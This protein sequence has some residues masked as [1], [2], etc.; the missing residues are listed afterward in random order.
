MRAERKGPLLPPRHISHAGREPRTLTPTRG[1]TL[2][3]ATL[4]LTHPSA[5]GGWWAGRKLCP[6][7]RS[8]RHW[9]SR[10]HRSSGCNANFTNS[11]TFGMQ[12]YARTDFP[13]EWSKVH[14]SQIIY[15]YMY[16]HSQKPLRLVVDNHETEQA[17]FPSCESTHVGIWP[18]QEL[19]AFKAFR[20]TVHKLARRTGQRE[21]WRKQFA[22]ELFTNYSRRDGGAR[23]CGSAQRWVGR[24]RRHVGCEF[25]AAA[26]P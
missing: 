13:V 3:P 2:M 9:R 16:G 19:H 11:V 10:Q 22:N 6:A 21:H 15:I 20:E 26:G 14:R 4:T 23:G 12:G 17:Q 25:H 5:T 1:W 7:P 8:C 18:H 24:R